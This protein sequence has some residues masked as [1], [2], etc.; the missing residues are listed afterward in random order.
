[1]WALININEAGVNQMLI[2]DHVILLIGQYCMLIRD[3]IFK[4]LN[5]NIQIKQL[6]YSLN[7]SVSV[8]IRV[9][10]PPKSYYCLKLQNI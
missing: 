7:N 8:H 10:R 5:T 9:S 3:I 2:I 6:Y 1:M 4:E